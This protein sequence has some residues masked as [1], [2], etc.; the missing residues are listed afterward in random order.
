M[1]TL[2]EIRK[3]FIRRSGRIDLA[4]DGEL[5]TVDA[6]ADAFIN[7]GQRLLDRELAD[8]NAMSVVGVNLTHG[9][10]V[11][12]VPNL[13]VPLT[14][15]AVEGTKRRELC[16]TTFTE[17]RRMYP[18]TYAAVPPGDP[19]HWSVESIRET[20]APTVDTVINVLPPVSTNTTIQVYG[21][22]YAPPLV[23]NS[24]TSWWSVRHPSLLVLAAL[25][26]LEVSMR[27]TSGAN[28]WMVQ[29]ARAL[30]RI[31]HDVAEASSADKNEL[32]G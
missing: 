14:V 8:P 16:R 2:L 23:V 29:I 17:M 26:E 24:D 21:S 12:Q 32:E 19:A 6:G 5:A 3:T 4:T 22:F 20:T 28:D 25:H 13:R 15:W 10:Y 27:N 9:Q 1:A 31:D 18:T 7:D 11:A 30:S